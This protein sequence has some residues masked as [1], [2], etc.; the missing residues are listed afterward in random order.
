VKRKNPSQ[1]HSQKIGVNEGEGGG[2]FFCRKERPRNS[3]KDAG[4]KRGRN[5]FL[6]CG[7]GTSDRR[8]GL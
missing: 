5:E 2:E 6:G 3:R 4:R 8:G 7:R 1:E